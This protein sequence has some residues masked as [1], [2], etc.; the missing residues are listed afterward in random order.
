MKRC[1]AWCLRVAAA[2]VTAALGACNQHA[3]AAQ[4]PLAQAAESFVPLDAM[5]RQLAPNLPWV[6]ISFN[7]RRPWLQFAI[8]EQRIQQAQS[9]GW[10]LCRP[11]S[12]EWEGYEDATGPS[13]TYKRLRT[14]VLY[15][16]GVLIQLIG[17]Y[18]SPGGAQQ[19]IQQGVVIAREATKEEARQMAG[20]FQLTCA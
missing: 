2:A 6:Q 3:P 13:L 9:E 10:E 12:A 1:T 19:P 4:A 7:V 17:M 8:D 20:N 14:Y 5:E 18:Q 16:E 11:A 15:R